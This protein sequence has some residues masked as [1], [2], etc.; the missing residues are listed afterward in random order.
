M[1][2]TL[3]LAPEIEQRLRNQ[4][5]QH[6]QSP[7]E[8]LARLVEQS[9]PVEPARRKRSTEEWLAEFYAWVATH[10]D[11]PADVDDSRET[12]YAGRGE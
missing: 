2:L 11:W 9:L 8:Y 10:A 3:N 12:I 1:S 4:A 5:A 7:E 6:G